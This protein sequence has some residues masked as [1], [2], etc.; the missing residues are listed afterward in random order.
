MY[1]HPSFWILCALLG[2]LLA[3]LLYLVRAH[4]RHPIVLAHG[5]GEFHRLIPEELGYGYFRGIP[6][7]LRA[8]GHVVHV[9]RVPPTATI[10]R[11]AAH[12]A[13]QVKQLGSRVNIVAHS[14][15]GLDARLAIARHGLD[16]NVASLTTIG[17]PHNGTPLA[18]TALTFGDFPRSRELLAKLGVDIG[19]VYDLSAERTRAFN[20]IVLDAPGVLYANVV[21]AVNL[22]GGGVHALLAPAHR[23]LL[24]IAG[25]NDGVVP[26]SSQRW[27]ETLEEI[28]ADHWAQIG[29]FARFDV[30]A[31]YARIAQ[32]LIARKL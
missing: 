2:W 1:E 18:D 29:W 8:H 13:Q 28:D 24:R 15:G 19:G 11:R 23:Y 27:G 21:A 20:Q 22:D 30:Q 26:A 14:M 9:L 31:L 6:A 25:P 12:L 3:L 32:H 16:K 4:T 10:E 7:G 17:T 5:W